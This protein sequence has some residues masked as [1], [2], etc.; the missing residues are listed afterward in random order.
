MNR[1]KLFPFLILLLLS[2]G[3]SKEIFKQPIAAQKF[4]QPF[5]SDHSL[6]QK[7]DEIIKVYAQKGVPGISV[8]IS[9]PEGLWEGGAGQASIE[10]Q[11]PMTNGLVH[12]GGSV[13][14]TYTA[15][16]VLKLSEQG[17]L[18]LDTKISDL[19]PSSIKSKLQNT[20]AITVRMLLS[21][22]SGI[23]DY[24]SDTD[25]KLHWYNDLSQ[26]WTLDQ[27]LSLVN[28]KKY[29]QPDAG[30]H[31]SNTNYVLLSKILEQV[32]GTEESR[33]MAQNIFQP[34][35]LDHTFYRNGAD[36]LDQFAMPNYY[37]DRF[38][39]GRLQNVSVPTKV[40]IYSEYGDGGIVATS[41][42]FVKFMDGLVNGRI[43]SAG[44]VEL[45]RTPTLNS[46]YGLG[47]DIFNYQKKVQFGHQGAVFGGSSLLLHFSEQ[48]T[49]LF[50]AANCDATLVGGKTLQFYH[51]MKNKI[52]DLIANS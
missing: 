10:D 17:K 29:Q 48:K 1:T 26:R 23:P 28:K 35:A 5:K 12:A 46:E 11:L 18:Q 27:I 22:R 16:A 20:S 50:I 8:A 3:C 39:D 13:T 45:M 2:F 40:E 43:L 6:G 42:D 38:G 33:W 32:S 49:S 7:I 9:N 14:K 44:N 47:L 34:L 25:F 30:F 31:Y 21:H 37:L 24:I 15:T 52:C 19:L 36:F 41:L 51:E 4:P